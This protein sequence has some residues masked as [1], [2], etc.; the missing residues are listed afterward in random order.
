MPL[1]PTLNTEPGKRK[2]S[3]GLTAVMF[4]CFICLVCGPYQ[5]YAW[6]QFHLQADPTITITGANGPTAT[7][8]TTTRSQVQW[9]VHQHQCH[10]LPW[11]PNRAWPLPGR[12]AHPVLPNT[13]RSQDDTGPGRVQVRAGGDVHRHVQVQ[14]RGRTG[15]GKL[16]Q[17][18]DRH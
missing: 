12:V 8:P 13:S 9:D 11:A 18:L 16:L 10:V 7:A 14:L 2:C 17:R 6:C 3:T 1:A 15:Q 5:R 4:I